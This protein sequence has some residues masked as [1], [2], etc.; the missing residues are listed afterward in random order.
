[1][2]NFKNCILKKVEQLNS[3]RE[4]SI[5]ICK[6]IEDDCFKASF[7]QS[8]NSDTLHESGEHAGWMELCLDEEFK[9]HFDALKR[10]LDSVE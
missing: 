8:V 9:D 10:L 7:Y 5:K 3:L 4:V 2:S 6:E 1:M